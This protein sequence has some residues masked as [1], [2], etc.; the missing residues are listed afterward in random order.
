[1]A[2]ATTA[3]LLHTDRRGASSPKRSSPTLHQDQEAF[4]DVVARVLRDYEAAHPELAGR[5]AELDLLTE[6]FA[7][8]CLNRLQLRNDR[9]M[10]DLADPA[11]ALQFAGTPPNPITGR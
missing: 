10:V 8:S 9:Q 3:A 11:G 6:R 7:R 1:L 2:Y 4:W 5:L